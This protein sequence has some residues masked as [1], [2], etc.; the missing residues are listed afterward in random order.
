MT[1][2]QS[3]HKVSKKHRHKAIAIDLLK[4][5]KTILRT[6]HMTS[7]II[8]YPYRGAYDECKDMVD[9]I[10]ASYA[11]DGVKIIRVKIESPVYEHYI[12]KSIYIESHFETTKSYFPI[13]KNQAK[14]TL[15]ATDREYNKN[16]YNRFLEIH[17]KHDLELCLYDT[18]PTEDL[19]WLEMFEGYNGT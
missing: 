15:L 10:V 18:F 16:L 3:I 17:E 14:N 1:G 4:P 9:Q 5:D 7:I 13:S 6:E 19:D 8:R 12:K 2:D 11:R